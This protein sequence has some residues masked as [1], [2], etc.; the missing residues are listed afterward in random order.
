MVEGEW[1]P[2]ALADLALRDERTLFMRFWRGRKQGIKVCSQNRR[3]K[4]VSSLIR[5]EEGVC[6]ERICDCWGKRVEDACNSCGRE[7]FIVEGL[8][9]RCV[10]PGRICQFSKRCWEVREDFESEILLSS[11]ID[12]LEW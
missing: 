5:S 12:E 7:R 8:Q 10:E 3:E 1:D 6:H 11:S 2:T 4:L 9:G